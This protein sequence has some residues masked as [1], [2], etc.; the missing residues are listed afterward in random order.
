MSR[1]L[2]LIVC[3]KLA[4]VGGPAL[5]A[6]ATDEFHRRI[7]SLICDIEARSLSSGF[8]V[9]GVATKTLSLGAGRAAD[10]FGQVDEDFV[11][12]VAA[13][14]SPDARTFLAQSEAHDPRGVMRTRIVCGVH[15]GPD[16][17]V[18]HAVSRVEDGAAFPQP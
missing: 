7:A 4:L 14:K 16:A 13:T 1:A 18:I 3:V 5:A 11:A 2:A 12:I 10:L 15:V 6:P 17:R 9:G 8:Q